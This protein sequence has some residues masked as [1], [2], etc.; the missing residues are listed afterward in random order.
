VLKRNSAAVNF[1]AVAEV[2]SELVDNFAQHSGTQLSVLAMQYYPNLKEI[3]LAVGDCGVGIRST[4]V[5]NPK[6]SYLAQRPHHEAI[7]KAFEECVTC[8]GE[9][10]MGLT[11]VRQRVIELGGA[12]RIASYDGFARLLPQGPY[13]GNMSCTLPGV[14]VEVRL[15]EGAAK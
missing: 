5:R 12:V 4:L 13:V 14:Q 3:V 2:V 15:P 6:F 11:Q 9:G 8:R 1:G 10:G 7:V